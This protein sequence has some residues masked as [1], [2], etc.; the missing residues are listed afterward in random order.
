M[1]VLA[2]ESSVAT[3]ADYEAEGRFRII[4][5]LFQLAVIRKVLLQRN[6]SDHVLYEKSGV[7]NL[8]RQ[9]VLPGVVGVKPLLQGYVL[10]VREESNSLKCP[11]C[12]IS[13][14][15]TIS[16]VLSF[17]NKA[18]LPLR[19]MRGTANAHSE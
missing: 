9:L 1:L 6:L 4:R 12:Q 10:N 15:P 3:K 13:T 19:R 2:V 17:R 16:C 11:A 14:N 18:L 8:L 7:E 5:K